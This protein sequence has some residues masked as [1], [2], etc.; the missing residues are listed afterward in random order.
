MAAPDPR[1]TGDVAV[2]FCATLVDEWVRRGLRHAVVAPGSR[3]TPMALALVRNPAVSVEIFHDER[4]A[5]FC[6]LGIAKATGVPAVLLC[7]SGTAAVHFHGAVVEAHH[8]AVPM[9]VCTADRPPELHGIGAPQTIDQQNL[10]GSAVRAFR[11][12]GV[13]DDAGR[14]RWRTLAAESFEAATGATPG[15]VHLN[16]P[17]REPLV[18]EAGDLPAVDDTPR[19]T[20][21]SRTDSSRSGDVDVARLAEIADGRRGVLIAGGGSPAAVLDL[22][23]ALGWPV[24]ADVRSGARAAAGWPLVTAFDPILRDPGFAGAHEP[25][26]I[27]RFGEPPASKVMAQWCAASG[28][29]LVQ[30]GA[31][32]RVFDPDR[33]A[34]E[35][36]VGDLGAIADATTSALGRRERD[37]E[38]WTGHWRDA[39]AAARGAIDTRLAANWCEPAV[40]AATARAMRPGEHLV[41]SSSMPVRD[42][43]WFAPVMAGVTVHSNRG[44]NGIDGVVSTAVG[45]AIGSGAPT[46]LL[47][48]DVAFLHDL[49]GLIGV[50]SRGVDLRIVV[51]NNDGGAIFSFLP[52]RSV[53][54]DR[55]YEVLFGTP[56]GTQL[57]P[58]AEG[59]GLGHVAVERVS[60]LESALSASN[61]S[62]GC[63]VIE[64][65]TDRDSNVELHDAVYEAVREALSS[66]V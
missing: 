61:G 50:T 49:N 58:L 8:G 15:P 30:V 34:A 7:T 44:T 40:A 56:H 38:G 47:I 66:A 42:L 3:S 28:A 53:L 54:G 9:L 31:D 19:R 33:S 51:T 11:D 12:A 45:V 35:F 10:Y 46:T 24:F 13:P 22:A 65:R 27:L 6:A 63:R 21:S 2:T 25:E 17:F 26:V 48:G 39:E 60:E 36:V 23:R 1:P 62:G 4:S 52:Q 37:L 32:G 14:D 18:G 59:H 29:R 57:G 20:D 43:E 64:A 5:G 55:E 16:L 41:V